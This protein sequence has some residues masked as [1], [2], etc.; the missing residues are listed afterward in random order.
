MDEKWHKQY[1][2]MIKFFFTLSKNKSFF[3]FW[4]NIVWLFLKL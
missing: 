2:F 3:D 4:F 1:V